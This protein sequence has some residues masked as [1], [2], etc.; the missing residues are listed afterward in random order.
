MQRS[1][2]PHLNHIVRRED[3]DKYDQLLYKMQEQAALKCKSVPQAIKF[4]RFFTKHN[5]DSSETS[6]SP[7]DNDDN[8][9]TDDSAIQHQGKRGFSHRLLNNCDV[10]DTGPSDHRDHSQGRHILPLPPDAR[11]YGRHSLS[12]VD[13][14]PMNNALQ[15][16]QSR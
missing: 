1:L 8:S 13:N 2:V 3:V 9:S 10:D 14:V 15:C 4:Q 6:S 16:D 11:Q 7:Y 5:D 12:L